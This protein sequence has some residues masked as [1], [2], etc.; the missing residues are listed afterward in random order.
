M[1][2][3]FIIIVCFCVFLYRKNK[4]GTLN[5]CSI[6]ENGLFKRLFTLPIIQVFA[7]LLALL[8]SKSAIYMCTYKAT[9]DVRKSL[10]SNWGIFGSW[11]ADAID[12]F[13]YSGIGQ[14]LSPA[15]FICNLTQI[16]LGLIVIFIIAQFYY[17][18]KRKYSANVFVII[19]IAISTCVLYCMWN[20]VYCSEWATSYHVNALSFGL[21]GKD[22]ISGKATEQT[23]TIFAILAVTHY[24]YHRWI[25]FYYGI[26]P[27]ENEASTA[28]R[29][30]PNNESK[31]I[32]ETV[33]PIPNPV[34][35]DTEKQAHS[36]DRL[37]SSALMENN[38]SQEKSETSDSSC[39]NNEKDICNNKDFDTKKYQKGSVDNFS[40]YKYLIT[41][42]IV[43]IFVLVFYSAVKMRKSYIPNDNVDLAAYD[44]TAVDTSDIFAADSAAI[45]EYNIEVVKPKNFIYDYLDSLYKKG[46]SVNFHKFIDEPNIQKQII[47]RYSEKFL[48]L[49][50]HILI[51]KDSGY[52]DIEDSQYVLEMAD[53]DN[54]Y[55]N[56]VV[57]HAVADSFYIELVI[58]NIPIK[59]DGESDYKQLESQAVTINQIIDSYNNSV[60]SNPYEDKTIIVEAQMEKIKKS[61]R[62]DFMY[63][64]KYEIV[65]SSNA[66][67]YSNSQLFTEFDYPKTIYVQAVFEGRYLTESFGFG[68]EGRYNYVFTNVIPLF[69]YK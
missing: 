8:Y 65:T 63:L 36:Q 31:T 67:F 56:L 5:V 3:V 38:S 46:N 13:L 41:S 28:N 69:W 11:G 16:L 49:L 55:Y 12:E 44:S 26:T 57:F 20:A 24:F 6:P 23:I 37:D 35:L 10:E 2:I 1:F 51:I 48:K 19:S 52:V 17:I 68:D 29:Q 40:K 62:D 59:E 66:L 58:N 9:D 21:L 34:N 22:D 43:I 50:K 7:S 61:T 15:T 33:V 60:R 18:K 45:T 32:N 4:N 25:H 47:N 53:L 64:L 27:K 42:G 14:I 30:L 54:D 39:S